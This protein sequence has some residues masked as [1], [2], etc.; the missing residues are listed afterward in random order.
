MSKN[1]LKGIETVRAQ[2]AQLKSELS[3][4]RVMPIHPDDLPARVAEVVKT[5]SAR[6]DEATLGALVAAST[7][8]GNQDDPLRLACYVSDQPGIL[9]AW[10]NPTDLTKK[11]TALARPH[12][13]GTVPMAERPQLQADLE[14]RLFEAETAEEALVVQAEAAGIEIF[15]RPDIDPSIVLAAD[16]EPAQ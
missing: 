6:V 15:R 1:L 16:L 11:L 4:L 9:H 5:L 7:P 10:L 12:A 3:A 14:R 13:T 8:P 2:I